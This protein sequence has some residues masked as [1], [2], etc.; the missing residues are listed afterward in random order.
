LL[1][2]TET[3]LVPLGFNPIR[4]REPVQEVSV[5]LPLLDSAGAKMMKLEEIVYDHL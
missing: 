1:G 5:T 2:Q 4:S 3:A